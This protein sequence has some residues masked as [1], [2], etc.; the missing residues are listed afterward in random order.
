[1]GIVQDYRLEWSTEAVFKKFLSLLY[2]P[3]RFRS[4]SLCKQL[5]RGSTLM[6]RSIFYGVLDSAIKV[7]D[8]SRLNKLL[9]KAGLAGS[10]M[11]SLEEVVGQRRSRLNE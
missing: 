5:V 1:M 11:L 8:A 3:K 9:G 7:K 4:R 6:E 10:H 2:F